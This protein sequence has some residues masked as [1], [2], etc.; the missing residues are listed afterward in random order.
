M[1]G[2]TGAVSHS[3]TNRGRPLRVVLVDD[4]PLVRAGLRTI[5]SSASDLDV[6]ADAACQCRAA[7]RSLWVDAPGSM[8]NRRMRA[9]NEPGRS[10][11]STAGEATG[12]PSRW[13]EILP[14][15]G[16]PWRAR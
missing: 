9:A 7:P 12:Q 5:L 3:G 6:V 15:R 8:V 4:D 2:M 1:A 10:C 13:R 11:G 14:G 16:H